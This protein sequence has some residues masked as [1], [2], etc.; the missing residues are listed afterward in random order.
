MRTIKYCI[1]F[2]SMCVYYLFKYIK[3]KRSQLVLHLNLT[4]TFWIQMKTSKHGNGKVDTKNW[5]EV[6][7]HGNL[8]L[9][10]FALF[11]FDVITFIKMYI[12]FIHVFSIL[13]KYWRKK[14]QLTYYQRRHTLRSRINAHP[15][16]PAYFFWQ[17]NPTPLLLLGPPVY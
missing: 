16:L 8:F 12:A 11:C 13:Q 4:F 14:A 2:F 9:P 5:I 10:K 3:S 1:Y 7:P 15:F 17:K 6:T